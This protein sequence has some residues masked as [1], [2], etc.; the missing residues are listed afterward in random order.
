MSRNSTPW[1][2]SPADSFDSDA[3]TRPLAPHERSAP[4]SVSEG[5]NS[6]L[7]QHYLPASVVSDSEPGGSDKAAA[8]LAVVT[9]AMLVIGSR[10]APHQRIPGKGVQVGYEALCFAP[11]FAE[12]T[13]AAAAE[14]AEQ[15]AGV[16]TAASA[17][18]EPPLH[19]I[20]QGRYSAADALQCEAQLRCSHIRCG[21]CRQEIWFG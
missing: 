18:D 11:S 14:P 21:H 8:P 1:L 20:F 15:S 2:I 7:A 19:V 5:G 10:Q 3:W 13:S 6:A 4:I 12:D 9:Q 17:P 16:A